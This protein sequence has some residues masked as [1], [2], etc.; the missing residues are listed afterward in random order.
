VSSYS[1]DILKNP[2]LLFGIMFCACKH[3]LYADDELDFHVTRVCPHCGKSG[4][5]RLFQT[6]NI[7]YFLEMIQRLYIKDEP[8]AIVLTV[9]A[10]MERL[11]EDLLF[12]IMR[13]NGLDDNE[14]DSILLRSWRLDDRATKVFKKYAK[15]TL[16]QAI[17]GISAKKFWRTWRDLQEKRDKFIHGRAS[18]ISSPDGK[19]TFE[20]ALDAQQVFCQVHNRHCLLL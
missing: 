1:D 20:L 2:T 6:Y 13:K 14:I 12:Q 10:L 15:Q 16:A 11:V 7:Q 4:T 17:E 9:C 19:K 3:C 8:Q 18:A 5:R